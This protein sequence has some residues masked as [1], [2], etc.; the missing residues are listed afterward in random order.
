MQIGMQQRSAET[1]AWFTDACKAPGQTRS[2]LARGLC[3]VMDRRGPGG[4]PCLASAPSDDGDPGG[5]PPRLADAPDVRL[6]A[7]GAM[8]GPTHR[9]VPAVPL[10]C[11]LSALGAGS[12][13]P[14]TDGADHRPSD[15]T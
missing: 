8:P 13:R 1:A 6:P 12:L 2:A 14:V 3:T 4:D 9:P 11:R 10:T 5:I 7:A 15:W